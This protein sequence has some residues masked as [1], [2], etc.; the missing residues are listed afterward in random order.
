MKRVLK[1]TVAVAIAAFLLQGGVYFEDL[2]KIRQLRQQ[3]AFDPVKYARDFWDN[4]LTGIL[5]QHD[6]LPNWSP[7]VEIQ[8]GNLKP[9]LFMAHA[10]GGNVLEY[11]LVRR[12]SQRDRVLVILD[13]RLRRKKLLDPVEADRLGFDLRV[14]MINT[15]KH[16]GSYRFSGSSTLFNG[17]N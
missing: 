10:E 6:F 12:G 8:P 5:D 1:Y 9:P 13:F 14:C 7:L 17:Q 2:S 11:Y 15:P 16:W 3:K 4:Q